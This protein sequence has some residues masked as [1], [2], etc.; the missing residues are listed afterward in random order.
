MNGLL[1]SVRIVVEHSLSGVKRARSVKELL[2]NTKAGF[3]D[4]VLFV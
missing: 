1:S 4:L 3:E 2:R